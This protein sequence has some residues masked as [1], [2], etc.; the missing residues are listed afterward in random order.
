MESYL[1]ACDVKCLKAVTEGFTPLAKDTA[2]TP[3][4]QENEK[5]NAKA[6]NHIFRGRCEEVFNHLRNHKTAH[7]LWKELCALHEGS[8]SEREEHFHLVMN[9][10]NTFEMLPNK[11]ANEMYSCLNVIVDELN[12]LGLNQTS[13]ADVA[14]KILC[15]L[16]IEKYGHIVTVLHQGDLSTATPTSILEKINAHEMYMHMNPQDS[17]S[18]AKKE[19][20]D[21]ALKASHKGNS[22]KI[23]VE[24]STSSDDDGS[25]A[26]MVRRTTKMLKKLNKNGVNFDS[27]KKKFFTS[28]K[29]KPIS[30]MD[31]YN[32]GE[33][34]H[35][36]H[37]CPKSKKD[38]YKKKNKEQDDSSDDEKS[39]KKAFKKR[40]GKEY[41]KKRN[42]K[43]YIVGD[44]L[45]DIESS[46]GDS[47][48]NESDNE[49]VAA[50]AID[51]PSPSSS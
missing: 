30:N 4:E 25:I 40:G 38:M 35:L 11:N 51:A 20:K 45:T 49:K 3:L 17:S 50:I 9:K 48:G 32:C 21:L 42:G 34:G 1:E 16:P 18:S 22:K 29:R 28:S 43:A 14:R 46:S 36:A 2:L 13:P 31:C 15:V 12:G 37:Q 5:W 27:K 23:E 47:S 41:H 7:E 39:N 10:L 6:K 8:K 19:K 26:L 33:L 44:W 24:S